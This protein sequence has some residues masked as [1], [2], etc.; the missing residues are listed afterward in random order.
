MQSSPLRFARKFPTVVIVFAVFLFVLQ[1][2]WLLG[3]S[4]PNILLDSYRYAERRAAFREWAEK[5]TPETKAEFDQERRLL[6]THINHMFLAKIALWAVF[7]VFAVV[8]ILKG[9]GR[10]AT[11]RSGVAC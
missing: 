8:W 2:L 10:R 9:F 4:S 7:D 3:A 11:K 1:L 5:Q 6:S